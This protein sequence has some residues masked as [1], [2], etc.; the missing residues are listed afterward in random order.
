MRCPVCD[1]EHQVGDPCSPY[2]GPGFFGLKIDILKIWKWAKGKKHGT[3]RC[4]VSIANRR[5]LL[6]GD[7]IHPGNVRDQVVD[8]QAREGNDE[9]ARS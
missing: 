2:Y 3:T 8:A 6:G 7:A 1:R 5:E 9:G 4:G